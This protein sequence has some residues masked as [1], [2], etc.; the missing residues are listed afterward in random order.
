MTAD[1]IMATQIATADRLEAAQRKVRIARSMIETRV[2]GAPLR[3]Q[4][5]DTRR[6]RAADA[7]LE[8]VQAAFDAAQDI[9]CPEADL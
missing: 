2:I 4:V 1:Q 5:E 3:L 7:A 8:A 6:L 9:D